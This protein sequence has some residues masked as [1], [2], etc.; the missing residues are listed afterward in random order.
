LFLTVTVVFLTIVSCNKEVES[1]NSPDE[2]S[3][4]LKP[5]AQPPATTSILKW[6]KTYGSSS[7]ELGFSITTTSDRGYVLAGS[8]VGNNGDVTS[9]HGLS[10]AWIIR[11][12]ASGNIV[13]Q[14]TFGGSS[15]DYAYSIS[16]TADDGLFFAG[17]P[18]A[19]TV[20][21]QVLM[22]APMPGS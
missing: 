12:N 5:A 2:F 15:T 21:L 19:T 10:D 3:T 18:V 9:N 11:I 4:S 13:W 20:T 17:Q 22:E 1:S 7:N 14:K 6:Q 8:T 16:A